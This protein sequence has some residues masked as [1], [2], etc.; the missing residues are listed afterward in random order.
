VQTLPF[1]GSAVFT[2]LTGTH[3]LGT[4]RVD[5]L[6]EEPNVSQAHAE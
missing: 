6:K 2:E 1:G 4:K 5:Y 3:L